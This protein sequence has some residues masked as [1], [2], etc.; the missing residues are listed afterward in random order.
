MIRKQN[1][2]HPFNSKA[3]LTKVGIG[4]TTLKHKKKQIIF[5][6]G[7][8]ADAVF[9]TLEGKVKLTVVSQRGK[10]AVVGVLGRSS[11]FGEACLAGQYFR[12]ATA[13]SLGDSTIIRIEK[14]AM[15]RELHEDHIFSDLFMAHLLS[16]NLR[17]EEDLMDQLFNS[18]EK[19]LARTLLLMAQ[20]GKE[21]KIGAIIPKISQEALAKMIGTTRLK[22]SFFMNRF[23]KLGFIDK[24]GGLRIH[25]SLL[26]IVLND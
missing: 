11:F 26:N 7:D 19:R 13:T 5:S 12:S 6:Q 18:S 1:Q 15:I 14:S 24:N 3:F 2:T 23:E 10:E 9:Y 21:S 25:S 16:R 17:I 22:V 20:Y 8:G 4:K